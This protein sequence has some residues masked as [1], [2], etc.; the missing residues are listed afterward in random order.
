MDSMAAVA[1]NAQQLPHCCWSLI[2]VTIPAV[3]QLIEEAAEL[4]AP[5]IVEV[6]KEVVVVVEERVVLGG[7]DIR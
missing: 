7:E 2:G 6:G 1:A 4:E 3:T 5:T